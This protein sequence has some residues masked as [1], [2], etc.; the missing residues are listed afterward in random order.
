MRNA[1]APSRPPRNEETDRSS[2]CRHSE[3]SAGPRPAAS[4]LSRPSRP[5]QRSFALAFAATVVRILPPFFPFYHE[6][7]PKV[8][9]V[10]NICAIL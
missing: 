8:T 4:T 10:P 7:P 9:H 6:I 3:R 2:A 1:A 5:L